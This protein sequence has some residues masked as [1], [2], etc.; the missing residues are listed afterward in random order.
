VIAVINAGAGAEVIGRFGGF[1]LLR[2]AGGAHGW[3]TRAD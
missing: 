2:E 3:S 1:V